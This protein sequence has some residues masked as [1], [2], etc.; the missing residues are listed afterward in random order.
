MVNLLF[1]IFKIFKLGNIEFFFVLS[2][3]EILLDKNSLIPEELIKVL[4]LFSTFFRDCFLLFEEINGLI[5]VIK[6][7]DKSNVSKFGKLI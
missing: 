1:L 2:L 3:L 6:L 5:S 7:L 4:L